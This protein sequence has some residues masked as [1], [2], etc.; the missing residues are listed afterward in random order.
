MARSAK[1]TARP[2]LRS[3]HTNRRSVRDTAQDQRDHARADRAVGA[4]GGTRSLRRRTRRVTVVRRE[5]AGGWRARCVQSR[6]GGTAS[7][8]PTR[9]GT[10]PAREPRVRTDAARRVRVRLGRSRRGWR[11]RR[12]RVVGPGRSG[13]YQGR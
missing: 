10:P 12:R 11:R 6:A 3:A 4:P 9:S 7:L 8:R 5:P 13:R 1:M 2:Q